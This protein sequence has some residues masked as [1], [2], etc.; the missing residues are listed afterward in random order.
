MQELKALRAQFVHYHT[1]ACRTGRS[2]GQRA[3]CDTRAQSVPTSTKHEMKKSACSHTL[4]M[5]FHLVAWQ[6]VKCVK[7]GD[8]PTQTPTAQDFFDSHV[9]VLHFAFC[10][11]NP[12]VL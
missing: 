11:A 10:R 6:M 8:R 7:L 9:C 2:A 1:I 3:K 12:P 5:L 4:F